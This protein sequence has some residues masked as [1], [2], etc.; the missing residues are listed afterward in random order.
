MKNVIVNADDFGL[1]KAINRG[2]I[3]AYQEGILTSASLIPNMP[4]YEDAI[5]L[6]KKNPG[7]GIGVHLNLIRGRSILLKHEIPTL[8][9]E[10]NRFFQ[11]SIKIIIG[12]FLGG[13]THNDIAR[14]LE[15]QIDKVIDSG[16][17]PSHLDSEKHF[18]LLPGIIDIVTKLACQKGVKCVRWINEPISFSRKNLFNKQVYKW[19]FLNYFSKRS[20]SLLERKNL[21]ATDKFFGIISTGSMN[22]DMYRKLFLN[23]ENGNWEIMTHPGY[24]DSELEHL[25]EEVGDYFINK[26]R[27]SELEALL[28]PELKYLVKKLNIRLINFRDLKR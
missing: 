7:L 22:K 6:A 5:Y 15:A 21:I 3:Q 10:K 2:I 1:T 14:E 11:S 26:H 28:C 8:V 4:A 19:F 12:L 9:D 18:H 23:L 27:E 13:I 25:K 16:I 20:T 17:I 24:A